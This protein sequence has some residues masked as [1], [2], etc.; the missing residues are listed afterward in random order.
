MEKWKLV[1]SGHSEDLV[2]YLCEKA[3]LLRRKVLDMVFEAQ[4]GHL[5]GS[6]SAAEIVTAL[7]FH[8]LRIDPANPGWP[9]RDRFLLSKGHAAPLLY[10]ALAAR[11]YFPWSELDTFRRLGSRLAGHPELRSTP[12]V[13][14]SSGPLGHGISVGVG[15]A[16]AARLNR[17]AYRTYVLVSDGELQ[18]GIL[19]EGAMAAAKFWLDGLTVILDFNGV[20]LDGRV[21]DI[22]P[23]EPVVDK[24]RA[25]NWRVFE[26]DGHDM[27]AVLDALDRVCD[28]PDGPTVIVAHTTKGKGVSFMEGQASWHGKPPNKEQYAQAV[29]DLA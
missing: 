8:H 28:S 14:M 1:V 9:E 16:L 22:M 26:V 3:R 2:H 12:G 6:F 25:F 10:A 19:W 11:G 21:A 29:L 18:S 17:K 4:T 15:L 5:G 27:A 23:I 7:Y 24:W 20:Q 13:D